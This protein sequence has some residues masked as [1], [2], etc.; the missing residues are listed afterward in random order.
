MA[1]T[2]RR[3]F[4]TNERL[5]YRCLDRFHT[6]SSCPRRQHCTMCSSNHCDLMHRKNRKDYYSNPTPNPSQQ[7]HSRSAVGSGT[8]AEPR[9]NSPRDTVAPQGPQQSHLSALSDNSLGGTVHSSVYSPQPDLDIDAAVGDRVAGRTRRY[10]RPSTP[11]L[12]L[13]CM[14]RDDW[15]VELNYRI[16]NKKYLQTRRKSEIFSHIRELTRIG[17][18]FDHNQGLLADLALDLRS[19]VDRRSAESLRITMARAVLN[20]TECLYSLLTGLDVS[21]GD[22]ARCSSEAIYFISSE[23]YMWDLFR[24]LRRRAQRRPG[25]RTKS[26]EGTPRGAPGVLPLF[27]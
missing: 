21:E 15:Q 17:A 26:S 1:Y 20:H 3:R 10:A 7:F 23:I 27:P 13:L 16:D 4:A 5:C 19:E 11:S 6:A 8:L 14:Q 22:E 9:E 2:A 12:S 18:D 24:E 25:S